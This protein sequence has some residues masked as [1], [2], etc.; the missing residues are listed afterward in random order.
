MAQAE[1][2]VTWRP[3]PRDSSELVLISK[4]M[5]AGGRERERKNM[6]QGDRQIRE[7]PLMREGSGVARAVLDKAI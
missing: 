2:M 3:L 5:E 1:V 6:S 7:A 4:E